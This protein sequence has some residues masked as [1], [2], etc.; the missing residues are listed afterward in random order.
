M[1][2]TPRRLR[3]EDWSTGA[4]PIERH[5]G[6]IMSKTSV[7]VLGLGRMGAAIA[8]VFLRN[9]HPTT[10]WNRT[11]GKAIHLDELGAR[12]ADDVAEAV[13]ASELIVT[14]LADTAAAGDQLL[15]LGA[16]LHGR[17]VLN[18]ATGRPDTA[19]ELADRL[20]EHGARFL[21]G[22]V[23]GVPQTVGTPDALLVYSGETGAQAEFAEVIAE[24]GAT[25]YVGADAGLA[26]L[27]DMAVLGGM[28]GLFGGFFQATAMVHTERVAAV[29]FTDTFLVPWLRA[30]LDMLPTLAAEIDSREFPVNFS[31]LAVNAAGLADIRT[32]SRNQGVATDLLDP[33][34]RLFDAE[35]ERGHGTASFTRAFAGL[36][37]APVPS[38]N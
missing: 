17:T 3:R 23:F 27:H 32:T 28:Y 7:T 25:K 8:E 6:G 34:Q 26:A 1:P 22:G 20:A 37:D 30:L 29:D 15:P 2:L 33:L 19:R 11:P 35:V 31:D 21:D 38:A 16:A 14:V 24:F 12:R 36:L 10:V 9:G 13:A 4:H 18:V 5:D